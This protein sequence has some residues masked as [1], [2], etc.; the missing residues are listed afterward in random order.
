MSL[1]V[2]D[3]L[4]ILGIPFAVVML[5]VTFGLLVPRLRRARQRRQGI[6]LAAFAE[7]GLVVPPRP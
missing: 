2:K 6:T 5:A 3:L 7:P 4:V 1:G